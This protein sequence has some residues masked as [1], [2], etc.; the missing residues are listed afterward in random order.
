MHQLDITRPVVQDDR[1]LLPPSFVGDM[2]KLVGGLKIRL[3]GVPDT[4]MYKLHKNDPCASAT[5]GVFAVLV[6]HNLLLE[7]AR[8]F[9]ESTPAEPHP[10]PPA[11]LVRVWRLAHRLKGWLRPKYMEMRAEAEQKAV[12][13]A[14]CGET[15]ARMAKY[16]EGDLTALPRWNGGGAPWPSGAGD[17]GA[18]SDAED[19]N[20][21]T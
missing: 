19:Q 6:V 8:N 3:S 20:Q 14:L 7:E 12:M 13:S 10:D 21:A 5:Y 9:V 18:D 16:L 15:S 17:T 2:N 11:A 4:S 1:D